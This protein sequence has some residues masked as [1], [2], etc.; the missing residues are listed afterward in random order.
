MATAR[1]KPSKYEQ[2]NDLL[3][4]YGMNQL[5]DRQFW[6]LMMARGY[7]QRDID[8]WCEEYNRRE[9]AKGDAK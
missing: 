4:R 5:N 2:L 6:D 9:M 8:W 1:K 7:T 3:R